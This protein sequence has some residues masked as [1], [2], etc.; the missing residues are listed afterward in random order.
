VKRTLLALGLAAI[1]TAPLSAQ[2]VPEGKW[3]KRPRI[4]AYISLTAEQ[5]KQLDAIFARNRP[6]IIDLKADLEKRQFE[7]EQA[8]EAGADRK[9]VAD[10]IEAR[11]DARAKLQKELSLMLLDMRQ[12]LKP[13]QWE[14][15]TRLQQAIRERMQ[16]RRRQMREDREDDLEP[17]RRPPPPDAP[18]PDA[19]PP[20]GSAPPVPTRPHRL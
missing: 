9:V 1:T 2:F 8:M 17:E 7:Y 19:P 15:L 10:R 20:R 16:Q 13:E 4:A 12:V 11:E 5:E 18:P 3:W 14:K 6:H